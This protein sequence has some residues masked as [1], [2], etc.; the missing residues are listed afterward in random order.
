VGLAANQVGEL[1]RLVVIDTRPHRDDGSIDEERM[2]ERE[3]AVTYPLILFN[4]EVLTCS[5]DMASY[6]EGCLSVP[7]YTESVVRPDFV[8]VRAMNE[9]GE[10]IEFEADGLLAVCIQHE[11][12]H[13]EGKLF[14]DRL[15]PIRRNI[16]KA[17]IKKN[18][19]SDGNEEEE[20][21]SAL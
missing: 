9:K 4:P 15:T 19:Y 18:G 17:K 5:K 1:H 10:K 11:I 12:D 21:R 8:R 6:E 20:Q 3:R 14:L 2:T 16:I 13:L 7:G